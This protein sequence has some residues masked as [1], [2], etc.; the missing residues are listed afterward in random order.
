MP[1]G[2][3]G[4]RPPPAVVR[5]TI[6]SISGGEAQSSSEGGPEVSLNGGIASQVRNFRIKN[7]DV[8]S[9]PLWLP[10]L[11]IGEH[12]TLGSYFISLIFVIAGGSIRRSGHAGQRKQGACTQPG[13]ASSD[14]ANSHPR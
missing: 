8:V 4:G 9:R 13:S 7:V 3:R 1:A 2:R 12:C 5:P 10:T 11:V 6:S 14:A